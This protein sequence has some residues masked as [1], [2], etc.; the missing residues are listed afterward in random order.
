MGAINLVAIILIG[1]LSST[2]EGEKEKTHD[3]EK[4]PE[5]IKEAK[6]SFHEHFRAAT[7]ERTKK[8]ELVLPTIIS[9]LVA[10]IIFFM[11]QSNGTA[12][13]VIALIAVVL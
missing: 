12:I 13:Q 6:V 2:V 7:K 4:K 5:V 1:M 9:V 10:I 11:F 3:H 8:S